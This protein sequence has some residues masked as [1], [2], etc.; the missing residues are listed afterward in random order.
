MW[1]INSSVG[2]KVV[3]SV[4]GTALILFVTFHM[5]MNLVAIF[6]ADGYNEIC[7]FLGANWYA[8]IATVGLAALFIIHI[9]YA[10]WL[11]IQ[12][13]TARGKEH[14][15]VTEKPETVEWASQNMLVLGLIILLGICLHLIN[16]WSNMQL[17]ELMSKMGYATA[18]TTFAAD[19]IHYIR[20]TFSNVVY[21]ILYLVW[22]SAIWFH[23]THGFWSAMQTLGFNNKIWFTRWKTISN[24]YASI[25]C[26]CFALVIVTFYIQSF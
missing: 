10:F 1:L 13:R 8:L 23:M 25:V 3:M 14:Y 12:N 11:T 9:I 22:L 2:R 16:F 21:V 24:I 18:D 15:A 20:A 7:E 17:P 5:A 19:G 26:L 6:S 4:T